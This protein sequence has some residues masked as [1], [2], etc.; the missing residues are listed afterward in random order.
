[1]IRVNVLFFAIV[2]ERLG[3]RSQELEIPKGSSISDLWVTLNAT[4]P[5][6]DALKPHIRTAVNM[7]FADDSY[8]L[9]DGDEVAL[10][11]PVAGGAPS[12]RMTMDKL[13]PDELSRRVLTEA[14]GAVVTFAGAVRNHSKG[15]AVSFLEYEAY[16]EM[17][18][19]QM[20]L[21]VAE[22]S[23]KWPTCRVLVD[24]RYGRLEIGDLAVVIAVASPHRKEAFLACEYVIDRLKETA[25]IWKREV[26]PDGDEWVGMGP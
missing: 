5:G 14:D 26:G 9:Q 19:H 20:E 2:R 18:V 13:D 12:A 22:V 3:E 23:D 15:R 11:P 25:P 21:V 7:D 4:H 10:I 8:V 24:H 1:M 17:A 6:M 16:P